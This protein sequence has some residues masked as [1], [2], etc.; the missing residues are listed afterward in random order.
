MSRL[1]YTMA[2]FTAVVIASVNILAAENYKR[3]IKRGIS[4][5]SVQKT[6]NSNLRIQTTFD[7]TAH[8]TPFDL[9]DDIVVTNN[10]P[11]KIQAGTR[12]QWQMK[13]GGNQG[14]HILPALEPQE[15]AFIYNAN[16]GGIPTGDKCSASI[17]GNQKFKTLQ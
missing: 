12:I 13:E 4:A 2:T 16:P 9:P 11:G 6:Y 7:C 10:G 17:V 1:A 14:S 15:S 5:T 3:E 8:G